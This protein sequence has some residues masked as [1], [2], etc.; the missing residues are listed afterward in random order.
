MSIVW[1]QRAPHP[2]AGDVAGEVDSRFLYPALAPA[3]EPDP[4][5]T[6]AKRVAHLSILDLSG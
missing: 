3:S 1:W 4:F 5:A 6:I 2:E